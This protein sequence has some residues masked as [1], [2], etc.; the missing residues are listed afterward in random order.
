MDFNQI[1]YFLAL[2]DTLSFTRAAELSN[3]TQPPLTQ[4]IR[5][6]EE[7]LGGQLVLRDGKNTHLS[8]LG[9]TLRSQFEKIDDTKRLLKDTAQAINQGEIVALN[10]GLMCTIGPRVLSHFVMT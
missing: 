6:L 8:Q 2:T 3:V 5:C 7:E 1:R 10:I 4:A 9:R